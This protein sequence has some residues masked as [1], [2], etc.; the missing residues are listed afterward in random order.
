MKNNLYLNRY[1]MLMLF[2]SKKVVSLLLGFLGAL[3]LIFSCTQVARSSY[4]PL[5][6]EAIDLFFIENNNDTVLKLLAH[7]SLT[8]QEASRTLGEAEQLVHMQMQQKRNRI[9]NYAVATVLLILVVTLIV[10]TRMKQKVQ[11][12]LSE[13]VKKNISQMKNDQAVS[14]LI[15]EQ[16]TANK[17]TPSSQLTNDQK[18]FLLFSE[19]K[20]WL[21]KDKHYL[22]NDLDLNTAARELGTNR[23]YLSKAINAQGIRFSELVNRYRVQEVLTIF[24]DE[25]DIRNNYTLSEIA[26]EAGFYTK[27]VFFD[28]FRK[29]TG[30]T[31]HQFKEQLRYNK[32]LKNGN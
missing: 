17:N 12:T 4:P 15:R 13:L 19:F 28:T 23:S 5:L 21:E 22:R 3:Y 10:V 20:E 27:S 7:E 24:E 16:Q 18:D 11:A 2:C 25:G 32:T 6:E 9:I 31:P 26:S 14:H 1:T 30:M 29:E 8:H